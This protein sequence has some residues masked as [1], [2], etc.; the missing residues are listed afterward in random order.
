MSGPFSHETMKAIMKGPFQSSPLIVDCQPQP[1][2]P[3]K[4]CLCCH[5]SKGNILH[6]S[7]NSFI[8]KDK[9][10]TRFTSVSKISEIVS[11]F[12]L[13]LTF[14]FARHSVVVA[15]SCH[16]FFHMQDLCH[17]PP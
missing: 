17:C 16:P 14:P 5:L 2:G 3:D 9:F 12:H 1:D 13:P 15:S 11:Q 8:E 7:T 4:L 10:L 6:P